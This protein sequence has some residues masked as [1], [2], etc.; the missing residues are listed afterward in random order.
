MSSPTG[1]RSRATRIAVLSIVALAALSATARAATEAPG[2]TF[3]AS[4]DQAGEYAEGGVVGDPTISA[5]GR[6]VAFVSASANLTS[7]ASGLALAYVKDLD[8]GAV[9]LASRGEGAVGPVPDAAVETSLLAADGRY[10][11]FQSAAENLVAGLP[12]APGPV[13]H[14]YRRD[15]QSGETTLVDRAD[16]A[17]GEIVPLAATVLAVSA[18]GRLVAFS[19]VAQELDDPAAP[20]AEG[21]ETIYVRDVA[22][23]ETTE[24]AAE[25]AEEAAFSAD[26][27]YLLFT[28]AAATLPEATGSFEAYRRDLQTG[29][30]I[31]VSRTNPTGPAPSGEPA[32]GEAYEA[33]FVGSS[34]CQV[35]F[36]GE[37][38]TNLSPSGGDPLRGVYLRDF[39]G[40][41]PTTTLISLNEEGEP[42]EQAL[43]P[44]T[45]ADGQVAFLAQFEFFEPRHL[46]LRDPATQR[47]TLLDRA[48]GE[49]GEPANGE[50]VDQGA[51]LV[52]AGGCRAIFTTN[53]NNLFSE[54]VALPA[55][56]QTFVRQIAPCKVTPPPPGKSG[57]PPAADRAAPE[58]GLAPAASSP[59]LAKSVGVVGLSRRAVRISFDGPGRARVRIQRLAANGRGSWK[60]VKS[61]Y[62]DAVAA[63]VVRVRL[64][65][66]PAGRY[67]LKLR[68][69]G[70]PDNPTL[71]RR[72]PASGAPPA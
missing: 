50:I 63:G 7:A 57:P 42:F 18:D 25:G 38:T 41:R 51:A 34:D 30:T 29:E 31:L 5:D 71:S 59:A 49:E 67:R 47:T 45:T 3:A 48:T 27:R 69:Q 17:A 62:V 14:V 46:F 43:F 36:L 39:C 70:D 35:A 65:Q 19:D 56:P 33:V 60:L 28:S 40:S 68:L 61:L 23:G 37:G 6:L 2:E 15:L 26:D 4:V 72:L 8:T 24:I 20:H 44:T 32:D 53:A 13:V 11:V 64:P 1:A 12:A 10:L 16:G 58:T 54:E 9:E 21:E 66:L 55:T 52:A 22:S